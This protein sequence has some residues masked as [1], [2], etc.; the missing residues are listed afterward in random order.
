MIPMTKQARS[1]ERVADRRH[2]RLMAQGWTEQQ[3][4]DK[5]AAWLCRLA[6]RHPQNETFCRDL[7][8]L[9]DGYAVQL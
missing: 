2:T 3:A 9:A 1:A 5:V 6:D 4:A 7:E 8:V